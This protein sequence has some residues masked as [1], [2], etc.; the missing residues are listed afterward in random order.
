M[1]EETGETGWR[2]GVRVGI[3]GEGEGRYIFGDYDPDRGDEG[4]G[5]GE[6]TGGGGGGEDASI[7]T[8]TATS[9]QKTT[10]QD[11]TLASSAFLWT[12]QIP[13]KPAAPPPNV[14][15]IDYLALKE[16]VTRHNLEAARQESLTAWYRYFFSGSASSYIS[17]LDLSAVEA[18]KSGLNEARSR[19]CRATFAS[20][21]LSLWRFR[22]LNFFNAVASW[23]GCAFEAVRSEVDSN[24]DADAHAD[25]ESFRAAVDAASCGYGR[26]AFEGEPRLA[27]L[28]QQLVALSNSIATIARGGEMTSGEK[29]YVTEKVGRWDEARARF[30]GA[31]GEMEVAEWVMAGGE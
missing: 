24:L 27:A 5:E 11:D 31:V 22:A 30:L 17:E 21:L 6:E 7:T 29:E 23:S 2:P 12:R 4:E 3:G 15:R 26:C 10:S 8:T 9:H 18:F 16:E 1:G 19:L 25:V 13:A 28:L 14:P 20:K